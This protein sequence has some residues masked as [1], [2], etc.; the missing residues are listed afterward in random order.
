M[1]SDISKNERF[2]FFFDRADASQI[3]S[4]RKWDTQN[5]TKSPLCHFSDLS[6]SRDFASQEYSPYNANLGEIFLGA[7]LEIELEKKVLFCSCRLVGSRNL[8]FFSIYF[9]FIHF[10]F[11]FLMWVSDVRLAPNQPYYLI[12]LFDFIYFVISSTMICT[13][14]DKM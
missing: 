7:F 9:G 2:G 3:S 8:V 10:V 1:R 11:L 5:G 12:V 6:R 4:G 14:A 13:F